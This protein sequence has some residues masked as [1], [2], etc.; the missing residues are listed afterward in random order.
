MSVNFAVV[1]HDASFETFPRTNQVGLCSNSVFLSVTVL[2][3]IQCSPILPCHPCISSLSYRRFL[4]HS[5]ETQ[6]KDLGEQVQAKSGSQVCLE[7]GHYHS[8]LKIGKAAIMLMS[9]ITFRQVTTF[10]E[11]LGTWKCQEILQRSGK[12]HKV[13]KWSGNLCSHGYLIVTP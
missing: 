12:R 11:F 3:Y 2:L 6:L 1:I 10:L 4:C 9:V 7:H 13:S 5:L 8:D